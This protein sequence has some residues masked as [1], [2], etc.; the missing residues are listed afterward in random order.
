MRYRVYSG[1]RGTESVSPIEKD[2]F[3][4]KE[5]QSLDQ[6]FDWA[7]HVEKSGRTVVLIEGDDGTHLEKREIAAAIRHPESEP[8]EHAPIGGSAAVP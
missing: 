2:R 8:V 7:R 6:A 4:F 5:V 3:L 1:P